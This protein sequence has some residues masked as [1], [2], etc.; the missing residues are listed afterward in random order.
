MKT[1]RNILWLSLLFLGGCGQEKE[2]KVEQPVPSHSEHAMTHSTDTLSENTPSV[3]MQ[4]YLEQVNGGKTS[5]TLKTSP[6]RTAMGNIGATHVHVVYGSPGVKG[7][8]IWGGLVAYGQVWVT[9]AH[10]AT[11]VQFSKDVKV[12]SQKIAAGKYALFTIPDKEQWTIILNKNHEQ[13]LADEYSEKE[14]VLRVRIAPELQQIITQRLTYSIEPVSEHTGQ[15]VIE[16]EKVRIRIPVEE[17][18]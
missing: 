15:L 10:Q 12:A 14:D 4:T 3:S 18:L 11:A 9:G 1:S 8:I 2:G 17:Q 13:H 5:D 6:V 7:R 16:W